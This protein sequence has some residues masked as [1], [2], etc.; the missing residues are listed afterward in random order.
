MFTWILLLTGLIMYRQT[1]N[2]SRTLV[3]NK[4]VDYP[5]VVGAVPKSCFFE[6]TKDSYKTRRV[7]FKFGFGATYIRGLAVVCL[8]TVSWFCYE[9][10]VYMYIY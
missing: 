6:F 1:S 3:G 10:Y 4:I 9:I 2:I 7:T 5:D 8:K